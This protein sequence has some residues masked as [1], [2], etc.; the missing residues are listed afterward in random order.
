M[1]TSKIEFSWISRQKTHFGPGKSCWDTKLI[2]FCAVVST[3]TLT[4]TNYDIILGWVGLS[5]LTFYINHLLIT[6]LTK[7]PRLCK[8]F[9]VFLASQKSLLVIKQVSLYR[10]ISVCKTRLVFL[11][12]AEALMGMWSTKQ[13]SE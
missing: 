1:I 7:T 13:W 11:L 8:P 2:P 6:L 5:R 9:C 3:K 12:L 4:N 10:Y